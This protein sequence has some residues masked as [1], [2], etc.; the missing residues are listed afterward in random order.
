MTRIKLAFADHETIEF[1]C[2]AGQTVLAAARSHG[3]TLASDCEMGDCQTCRAHLQQGQVEYD[4]C[5]SLSLS[6]EELA[7]GETLCCVALPK[8]D[9]QVLLPYT[10]ASLLPVK[11][12]PLK[13]SEIRPVA[14]NT[15]ALRGTLPAL[16]RLDYYP[17]QYVNLS[18]PGATAV[19]SYSMA[20]PPG[21]G[22]TLE[23]LIR[24][25]PQGAMSTYLEQHAQAG[26]TLPLQGPFGVF[27]LRPNARTKLMVAG[28][29]GIAPIAAM[30]RAMAADGHTRAP[31][32][33]CFG[34]NT[35]DELFY[36]DELRAL[37]ERFESFELRVAVAR[38]DDAWSGISGYVT[39]ALKRDDLD[40]GA[41]DAYLCGPPPM[42]DAARTW[43]AANG[44]P[45]AQIHAEVF[46]PTTSNQAGATSVRAPASE[47][48]H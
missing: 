38:P 41:A 23:F 34:V 13:V 8:T 31:V 17:G 9:V 29:T 14:R 45:A 16:A 4:P 26:D 37:G 1:D 24:C 2:D 15:Y 39:D 28:G 43:L 7:Q 32:V 47:A 3:M 11:S 12:Y 10:R 21:A 18:V 5:G 19:R 22:A 25:V 44:L 46:Q 40:A 33:V 48:A 30:L 27:H 35:T 36:V 42:I 6:D 20:N